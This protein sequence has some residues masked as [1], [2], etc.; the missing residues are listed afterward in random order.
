MWPFDNKETKNVE[1]EFRDVEEK[2]TKEEYDTAIN[3]ISRQ[4]RVQD[5]LVKFRAMDEEERKLAENYAFS[6]DERKTPSGRIVVVGDCTINMD[7]VTDIS[8][9]DLGS[10]TGCSAYHSMPSYGSTLSHYSTTTYG[11][12]CAVIRV[13]YMSGKTSDVSC[14]R[15]VVEQVYSGL[16]KAWRN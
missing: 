1:T 8:V 9:H 7:Y 15:H 6:Y 11:P 14:N 4:N 10:E 16:I 13:T 2:T 5:A 12:S 3:E